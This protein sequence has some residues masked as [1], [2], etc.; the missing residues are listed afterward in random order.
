[1][2]RFYWLFVLIIGPLGCNKTTQGPGSANPAETAIVRVKVSKPKQQSLNWF[3][4]QP[5]TVEPL[6]VTPIVAKLPGYIKEI[7]PDK[8]ALKAGIKLPGGQPNVIDIGSEVEAG[9]LLATLDV[10]ELEADYLEK[11]AMLERSQAEKVQA[12]KEFSV[13]ESQVIIATTMVDEAIAGVARADADVV[14]WKAELDQVNTQISGG[15]GEIQS[16]NVVTKSWEAARAAKLETEAKVAT[17]R[18]TVLERKAKKDKAAADIETAHTRVLVARADL[19]RVKALVG[20]TQIT[21]PFPGI[22][23]ARNVHTRHFTQPSVGS[24]NPILFTVARVDVLRVF[25]DI[26]EDSADK[27]DPGAQVVVRVPSLGGREYPLTVTRTTRVLNPNS[28]TV[29]VEIDIDNADRA[30]KPGTYVVARVFATT[31]NSMLIPTDCILAAD[32]THYIYLVE[33]GKVAKYRIQLGHTG[34]GVIEVFGRRRA[35]S[36]AGPW[37]KF[38]GSEQV[39]TGN[40]GAL[41]DGIAVAVE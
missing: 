19:E 7:A 2:R 17:A 27:A 4:E 36:T 35:L 22:V 3:I 25:V 41:A 26:P 24:Q 30:L 37:E 31:T 29:R 15:V 8:A 23:T 32:E 12:D 13:A 39:V 5:G 9:Q 40:L 14:R 16:R 1:V 38:T 6:E 18:A 33:G 34:N 10:P 21:A 28:R 20:Y 11:K